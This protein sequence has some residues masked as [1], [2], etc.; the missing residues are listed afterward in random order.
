MLRLD[1]AG[2][3]QIPFSF[4]IDEKSRLIV[5]RK[6]N[7]TERKSVCMGKGKEKKRGVLMGFEGKMTGS[8]K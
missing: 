1:R 8:F 3:K 6:M 7:F 5:A 4:A 2:E